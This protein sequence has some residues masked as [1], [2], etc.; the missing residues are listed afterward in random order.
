MARG[1]GKGTTRGQGRSAARGRGRGA[2]RGQGRGGEG[3]G[4]MTDISGLKLLSV[5]DTNTVL[6]PT[7]T[8]HR[9][10]GPDVPSNTESPLDYILLFLDNAIIDE[11]C[12]NTNKYMFQILTTQLKLQMTGCARCELFLTN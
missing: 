3:R 5:P 7:F 2:A 6:V 10:P 12:V 8:P 4:T 9:S 1:R 11:I